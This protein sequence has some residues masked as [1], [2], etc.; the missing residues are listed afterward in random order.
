MPHGTKCSNARSSPSL[1]AVAITQSSSAGVAEPA[2]RHREA[3][4]GVGAAPGAGL[5]AQLASSSAA[6]VLH[7]A[8]LGT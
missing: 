6:G 3:A 8:D 1:V 4:L 2:E 5:A 7:P